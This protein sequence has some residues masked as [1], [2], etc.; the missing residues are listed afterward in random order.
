MTNTAQDTVYNLLGTSQNDGLATNDALGTDATLVNGLEGNDTISTEQANDLAA[1]DMVGNEWR[2][3]DGEWVYNAEAVIVSNY[4]ADKSYNDIISTGAGNDVLLGN[5]GDDTLYAGS[6]DDIVN[7]GRGD[8]EARGGHGNDRINLEDGNDVAEGGYG[9]DT[10]NAGDGNDVVYGDV[11]GDNLLET[12]GSSASTFAQIAE[13]SAWTM[14]DTFGETSIAQSVETVIGETYTISFDLAANLAGGHATGAVEVLWNGEVIDT[15]EATSGAFQ[16][17]EVDVVSTGEEGALTF[18][19]LTPESTSNYNFEGPITSYEKTMSVGGSDV[20]VQAFAAG[21]AKLYQVIDGQLNVFDVA[22]KE[23][24]AVGEKPNFKINAAGFNVEADM[25]YGIAKSTGRDT[26]GNAVSISDIVMIDAAGDTYRVG[27]GFYGDYVGDFDDSGNLWTFHSAMNRVSVVDVN[28]FDANGNPIIS[29]YN[30]PNDLFNDRT[31]DVAFNSEDGNF[32][33]VVAPKTNGGNGKVVKIDMSTLQAGGTPTFTELSITGTLYGDDMSTGMAKGAY[34]A[35]FLDGEGNLY[36][37]LNKGDHDL[38]ASTDVEGAI[39]KIN[40]D[41]NTGQAYS[42]FMSEAPSTGS[43]DGAVDPRSID[44]FSEIDAEAAVLLREPALTL[45]EGGN[46]VLNGGDGDDEMHGNAGDDTLNGGDGDDALFGDQGNDIFNCGTGND[47]ASGGAGNDKIRGE[48]GNDVLLGNDGQDY[49]HAGDGDDKVEGGIGNDKLVGGAGSDT[50]EGGRGD[51]QLWGGNWGM[52]GEA[53]T[54]VFTSGS[55]KDYVHDFE[56]EHDVID[57]SAFNTT[58]EE[59]SSVTTDLGW[60]TVIDLQ[61]LDGGASN[62][63]I[64]LSS[65][66]ASALGVDS[67][68]F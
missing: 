17:F 32:Y 56:T 44:A 1:G 41:W 12:A 10:V 63:R 26:A 55:G 29:H 38:N 50:I 64:V 62:D 36:Y 51:D 48:N 25:I 33:A 5:G 42:E 14:V 66:D 21:Q 24:I 22:E 34:G 9:H 20:D 8:D 6:G 11:K 54:F 43:N 13:G 39:F 59:V 7:G 49:I 31:Y 19:A 2:F 4:G 60:A 16:T 35:V 28:N 57:L 47:W 46:D 58:M 23:Y 40:M 27:E 67:F 68:I 53:D 61:Q 30:L 65:V 37:G 15:V 3:I 45:V 52:D 18:N